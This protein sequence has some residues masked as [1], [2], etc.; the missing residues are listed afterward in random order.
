MAQQNDDAAAEDFVS[1]LIIR[2]VAGGSGAEFDAEDIAFIRRHPEVL[3]KLS[4]P[5]EVKRRFLYALFAI[6]LTMAVIAKTLQYTEVLADHFVANDLLTDVMFSMSVEL[7]GAATV[8]FLLE[9]VFEK[10]IQRNQELV[11]SLMA[12]RTTGADQGPPV[13]E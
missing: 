10:R 13:A 11:Q 12:E 7:F 9:L 1:S 2:D 8:A 3:D 5:L 4:D 6:A